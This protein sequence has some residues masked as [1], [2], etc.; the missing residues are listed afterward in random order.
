MKAKIAGVLGQAE[1]DEIAA[2]ITILAQ[3]STLHV[4]QA[5]LA[6]ERD[7]L[8]ATLASRP[9]AVEQLPADLEGDRKRLTPARSPEKGPGDHGPQPGSLD[10]RQVAVDG[11]RADLDVSAADLTLRLRALT[12]EQTAAEETARRLGGGLSPAAQR[13]YASLSAA[14]R[15][16][17]AVT[18]KGDYCGGCNMRVP[19][20]LLGEIRRMHRLHRC[21]SCKRVV[22]HSAAEA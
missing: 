16:P 12:A 8:I 5:R 18:L 21:P 14:R 6:R 13:I 4:A 17:L 3:L 11:A 1:S 7:A 15:L 2:D 10:E 19:S 22:S 20:G 9:R